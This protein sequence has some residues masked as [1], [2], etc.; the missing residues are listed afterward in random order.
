M[1]TFLLGFGIG[2]LGGILGAPYAGQQSRELLGTKAGE[3]L[4]YLK[5]KT[6][7]LRETA[8]GA[9]EKTKEAVSQHLENMAINTT[10]HTVY[11][12]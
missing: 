4:N 3:G 12:R 6:E 8:S 2:M 7:G 10:G 9:V 1:G 11:Q 5:D